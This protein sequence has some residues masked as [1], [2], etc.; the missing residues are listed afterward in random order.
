MRAN[1]ILLWEQLQ[2]VSNE[3]V[4]GHRYFDPV[5]YIRYDANKR[6]HI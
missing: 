4:N 6:H 3:T 2:Y 5:F 1:E